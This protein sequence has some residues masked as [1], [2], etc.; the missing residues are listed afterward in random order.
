MAG[1]YVSTSWRITARLNVNGSR[2]VHRETGPQKV[3][4]WN[5]IEALMMWRLV[6][7]GP[8]VCWGGHV[9]KKNTRGQSH[10]EGLVGGRT[11]P[12]GMLACP[13]FG[14]RRD[15]CPVRPGPA[16]GCPSRSP[17]ASGGTPSPGARRPRRCGG[18]GLCGRRP[19][20]RPVETLRVP[21]VTFVAGIPQGDG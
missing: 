9:S 11:S 12:P 13:G 4:P 21:C 8:N 1:R 16:C 5:E 15:R 19:W 20:R 6:H 14:L 3:M 7:E 10:A 2:P 18:C 17:P